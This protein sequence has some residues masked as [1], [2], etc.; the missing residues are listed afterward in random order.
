MDLVEQVL[1][2]HGE[3]PYDPV[4]AREYY[5]RNRELKGRRKGLGVTPVVK[6]ITKVLPPPVSSKKTSSLP[7][8]RKTAA[9]KQKDAEVRIAALEVKLKR[10]REILANLVKASASK[11]APPKVAA[12]TATSAGAPA[13]KLTPAQEAEKSRKAKLAYDKN[14]KET[15]DAKIKELD[16]QIKAITLKISK[17]KADLA[18]AKPKQNV[19]LR[20]S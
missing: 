8:V 18:A 19:Q 17:M 15:P 16:A 1:L 3:E 2:I 13:K 5:L 14:K 6:A 12:K 9:Q 4:K 10:L 20:R 11:K 7:P